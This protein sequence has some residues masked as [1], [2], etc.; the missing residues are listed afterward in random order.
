MN[1][2]DRS[3]CGAEER[4]RGCGALLVEDLRIHFKVVS[5]DA[6]K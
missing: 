5:D 6:Q 1:D 4:V 2:W 3:L